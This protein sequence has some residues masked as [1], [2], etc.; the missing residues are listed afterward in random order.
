PRGLGEG[1]ADT[2]Q[3]RARF[4]GYKHS[5]LGYCRVY[6]EGD[7]LDAFRDYVEHEQNVRGLL[8]AHRE[9][10]KPISEWP[11]AFLL[12][13]AM[14]PTRNNVISIPYRRERFGDEWFVAKA[15]HDSTAVIQ[16]NRSLVSE[17][18]QA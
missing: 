16:A 1:N 8:E 4:F 2:V 9:S 7:V 12:S 18:R 14:K 6:L 11:R 3:Q 10:G 17:L 13:S 15:P 5:Y